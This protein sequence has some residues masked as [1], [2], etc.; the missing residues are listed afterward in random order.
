M[1]MVSK[2]EADLLLA[3]KGRDEI[4]IST[5]RF[6]LSKI[7][8]AQIQ[9]GKQNLLTDAEIE[10]EIAKEVKSHRESIEAYKTAKREDLVKIEQAELEVLQ[11]Y[12]PA[13]LTETEIAKIVEQAI[14][15]TGATR[16][17]FGKI[18]G[19]VM[20]KVSGQADGQIVAEIVKRSLA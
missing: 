13:Q 8:N 19:A 3:Q 9:K 7:H 15:E 12:L 14:T 18:M 16:A 2:I 11:N 4:K 6:L 17:D 1:G 10:I 20:A 5:L